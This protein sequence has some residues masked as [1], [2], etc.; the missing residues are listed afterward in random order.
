[1]SFCHPKIGD[2]KNIRLS[3]IYDMMDNEEWDEEESKEPLLIRISYRL[4]FLIR[5]IIAIGM[6]TAILLIILIE[7]LHISLEEALFIS[8]LVIL[9][10]GWMGY[11]FSLKK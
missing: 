6:I 8:V 11:K 10:L 5:A 2:E 4:F 3:E 9:F 7:G 1:M